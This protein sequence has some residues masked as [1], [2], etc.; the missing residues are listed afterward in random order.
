MEQFSQNLQRFNQARPRTIEILIAVG[1]K[2]A[3][4]Y[5][6]FNSRHSGLPVSKSVSSIVRAMSKPQGEMKITSGSAATSASQLIHGECLPVS[7]KRFT[8]PAISTNSGDQLPAA[9]RG[10]IHSIQATV[11]RNDAVRAFP[12][13]SSIRRRNLATSSSPRSGAFRAAATRRMSDQTSASA[14]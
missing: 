7:P 12:A 2:D 4:L 14:F 11:G 3:I 9:I 13:V 5:Y 10:S 1:D 8:P 6:R